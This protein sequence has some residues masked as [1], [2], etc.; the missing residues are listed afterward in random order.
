[1][2]ADLKGNDMID[3]R[4]IAVRLLMVLVC[5]FVATPV[6]ASPPAQGRSKTIQVNKSGKHKA[7]GARHHK[8]G[9]HHR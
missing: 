7:G 8:R 2:V 5:V 1:M 9:S 3:A 4:R 6:L